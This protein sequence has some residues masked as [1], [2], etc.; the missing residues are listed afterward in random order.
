MFHNRVHMKVRVILL[1]TAQQQHNLRTIQS[2]VISTLTYRDSVCKCKQSSYTFQTD[3]SK[4]VVFNLFCT[5]THY[6]ELL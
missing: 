6:S 1:N 2:G 5:A 4:A 3:T